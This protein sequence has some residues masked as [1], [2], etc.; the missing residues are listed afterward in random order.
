MT[1]RGSALNFRDFVAELLTTGDAVDIGKPVS[2][3]LEAGAVTRRVYD[4]RSPAPLFSA[5]TEGDP[6][7]RIL[8]APAGLSGRPGE[9]YGRL[10]AHFGL[11]RD[12]T[13][14]DLLEKLISAMRAAPVPPR[15]VP[16]GPCKEN[17]LTGDDVDLT[18]FP[19]PLL[20]QQDGGR[21]FGTYGFHVVRTPDERW[22]SW[23]VSRTM[24]HGPSTLVGPAMPQQHLGMIHRM[25][26]ERGERTPWAM[27]LGAPPAALAAA[28]M[29]LPA[30]VDESGYV[31]A[32]TGSPVD[33]VRAETNDLYV[34]A[35]SEIVLE[36]YISPD[37]TAPEGPMGEYHGYS[38]SGSKPQPVFHVEAVTYRDQA[39][40]PV[41]VAGTP[42]EENHTI[43]GT[44]I[45]AAG[46]ELLRSSGLPVSMA[47]C[48]YEAATCWIVV[49]VDIRRLARTG[50]T[51]RQLVDAVAEVLFDSHTGW[52]VPKVLLV[53]DDIDITD[54][55]QVVWAMATRSH[56]T[57]G[58]YAYPQAPGIPMVP[59]LTPEEVRA[60]RGGKEIVSCLL[61][62]QFEGVTRATT[63]SF[64]N[65]YPEELRRRIVGDWAGY[66][67]PEADG[68]PR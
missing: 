15:V 12:T 5:L 54:I 60:G 66:G 46:L 30:E 31:G 29:P 51:E 4:T 52:L 61:P 9:T 19:V 45:S 37:E 55:D 62:E 53:A 42:P 8:G 34:P 56:P 22:T 7:F 20:H 21:Y 6:G 67:F 13:P 32:L 49:S 24:L 2:P 33:V 58:R 16:T 26:A 59:Y 25:W 64:D 36:G 23:S 39:I 10:A 40:L 43:W 50:M 68:S 3:T 44:M 11:G 65:S 63:A 38:F 18:R 35:N 14:R 17:V 57:T 48:S 47:W 27:V 28:G 1:Q 41:C